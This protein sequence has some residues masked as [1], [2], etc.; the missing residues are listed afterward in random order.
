M[1]RG[2]RL[3]YVGA[4]QWKRGGAMVECRPRPGRGGVA[5]RA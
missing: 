1:T 2:A 3:A 4:R 5:G